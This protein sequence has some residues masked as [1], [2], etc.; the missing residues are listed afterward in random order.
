[1]D[2]DTTTDMEHVEPT[3][4]LPEAV[5]KLPIRPGYMEQV[6]ND[7]TYIVPKVLGS[8]LER[9]CLWLELKASHY[10]AD[11]LMQSQEP[12]CC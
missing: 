11:K 4:L 7:K 10:L 9:V 12:S 6:L 1:M 2:M 5:M 3:G 8:N